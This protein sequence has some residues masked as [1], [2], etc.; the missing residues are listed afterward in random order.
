MLDLCAFLRNEL[1][2]SPVFLAVPGNH[3][4]VRPATHEAAAKALQHGWSKDHDVQRTFWENHGSSY[5]RVID[6][7]FANYS[8][9]WQK[10]KLPKPQLLRSGL[11]PG[12][13]A[14]T[15]EKDG[16]KLGIVGL[17]TAFLQFK[18]GNSRGQLAI[19]P[20]QFHVACNG[21]GASWSEMHHA[22][23][24]LTHHPPDWL[25]K[26][27]QGVLNGE[28][29][30]PGRFALHMFG[31]MHEHRY[32]IVSPGTAQAWRYWQT[33]SL[34]SRYGW[35]R[36]GKRVHGYSIG[37]LE[38]SLPSATATLRLWPRKA[39]FNEPGIWHFAQ[40]TT[41]P[42]LSKDGGTEQ[43]PIEV[44]PRERQRAGQR[45]SLSTF[46]DLEDLLYQL[47]EEAN[48][49][50]DGDGASIFL[51]DDD[52]GRFVLRESTIMT[53]FIG[54]YALE[55]KT[56]LAA[57]RVGLTT[58][59]AE[60]G[61]RE[62]FRDVR[63]ERRWTFFGRK[64][65]PSGSTNEHCELP[66]RDLLSMIV[67]P[68][69]GRGVLR[70]VRSR[71]T[72]KP[73]FRPHDLATVG[74][75][76]DAHAKDVVGAISLARLIEMGCVID[77]K[78]LCQRAVEI[79]AKMVNGKG[80]SIFLL[81]E[82]SQAEPRLYRCRA[83]TG[84]VCRPDMEYWD[85]HYSV[86]HD[87]AH[88]LTAFAVAQKRNVIV[89]DM[90][91]CDFAAE[92]GL[93]RKGGRGKISERGPDGSDEPTGAFMATPLFFRE[94]FDRGT[95]AMGVIRVT[96]WLGEDPFSPGERRRFF[97]FAEKLS[98]T[99]RQVRYVGLLNDLSIGSLSSVRYDT[100]AREVPRLVG[101][102]ACS[103]FVGRDVL[104][105]KATSGSLKA[106]LGRGAIEPYYVREA[107]VRGF[108]G[109]AAYLC[110]TIRWN[111]EEEREALAREGLTGSGR[112]ECEIRGTPARFL[113]V[114]IIDEQRAVG[115]IRVPKTAE[116][117]PFSRDDQ[118]MLES[119]AGHL[120]RLIG[121]ATRLPTGKR[122][123]V[124]P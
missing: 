74:A 46:F 82:A 21:D 23:L 118:W 106:K 120:G 114:P 61:Y 60:K 98:K 50:V 99:I 4:L 90:T 5:R 64:N 109:A 62:V 91:R 79:F 3:D 76:V 34:F 113:A 13:F 47:V 72:R 27:S 78:A 51:W 63:L 66:A 105:M 30:D 26:A 68:F 55:R 53:P 110:R 28:V 32:S 116:E 86:P 56:N 2:S 49:V 70:V 1:H 124:A 8:H 100:V 87:E 102:R 7:A 67:V 121:G 37:R 97:S 95:P 29:A 111:T 59:A 75:I 92:Y 52:S 81:D 73:E 83:S 36:P 54:K 93:L 45:P 108:T 84:L 107:S 71:T 44:R 119:I 48:R 80:C 25:D 24:L 35:R 33:S 38:V 69:E 88:H 89:D 85:Q 94:R 40:D 43:I 6:R 15:L 77:V 101:G 18:S 65:L 103:V 112:G 42:L 20:G 16:A 39:V 10:T 31:H 12:D 22:C 14:A 19:G 122:L 96:R 123:Q 58:Y 104:E 41:G 57:D 115:V 17:N 11:L 9:W 117:S